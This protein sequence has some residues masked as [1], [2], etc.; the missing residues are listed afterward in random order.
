MRLPGTRVITWLNFNEKLINIKFYYP[1]VHQQVPLLE[2][3]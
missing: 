2:S 1:T 3:R